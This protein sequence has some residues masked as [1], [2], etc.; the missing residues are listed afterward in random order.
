MVYYKHEMS[1]GNNDT[2]IVTATSEETNESEAE[3]SEDEIAVSKFQRVKKFFT[4]RKIFDYTHIFWIFFASSVV[5]LILETIISAQADGYVKDRAGLVL[6]PFSP[7]YG[8]GGV[9]VSLVLH[10]L[11]KSKWW[12]LFFAAAA[13]GGMIEYVVS[14]V[15]QYGFG[16]IAWDY[17]NDP[18]NINGRTCVPVCI[19]WGIGGLLWVRIL[20]PLLLKLIDLV[21]RKVMDP[22]TIGFSVLLILDV[23]LTIGAMG[24]WYDRIAGNEVQGAFQEFF[25]VAFPDD[26]ME[27]RFQTITIW[28]DLALRP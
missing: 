11:R 28:P 2:G 18:L 17:S 8:I 10:P 27:E 22:L 14:C 15:L 26:F 7:I 6:G 9:I 23:L 4:Y 1:S 13:L 3:L 19:I 16:I 12:I 25:N 5:G 24:C 20:L 21:P